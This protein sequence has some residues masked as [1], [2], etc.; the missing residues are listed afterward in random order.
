MKCLFL[1]NASYI[2]YLHSLLKIR[3]FGVCVKEAAVF[4]FLEL[5]LISVHICAVHEKTKLTVLCL[6]FVEAHIKCHSWSSIVHI[7]WRLKNVMDIWWYNPI[8]IFKNSGCYARFSSQKFRSSE[9]G[10]QIIF[11]KWAATVWERGVNPNKDV[12]IYF[13]LSGACV[14]DCYWERETM[15]CIRNQNGAKLKH[16]KVI[17]SKFSLP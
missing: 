14:L 12:C 8:S 1:F 11:L 6:F 9:T 2:I 17:F 3:L 7:A 13:V 16:Y 10:S 15:I 5:S 4:T